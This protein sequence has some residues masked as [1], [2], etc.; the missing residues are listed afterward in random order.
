MGEPAGRTESST[1]LAHRRAAL[2]L[3]LAVVA[4]LLI[5]APASLAQ[6]PAVDAGGLRAQVSGD[7]WRLSFV[8][9]QGEPVLAEHPG[10]GPGPAG[11]LGFRAAGVWRHATR[12][13]SSRREGSTYVAVLATTDPLRGIEVRLSPSAEGVIG[14]LAKIVGPTDDVQALGIGFEGRA[15]ERYLGFGERSNAV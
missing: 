12:V 2:G 8:G 5:S 15:S 9:P 14:L 13:V 10:T 4:G 6:S 11:T 3:A 1:R 7:P